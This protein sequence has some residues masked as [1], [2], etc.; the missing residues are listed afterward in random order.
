MASKQSEAIRDM[1]RAW[2]E[3]GRHPERPRESRDTDDRWGDVTAEPRGIDYVEVDAGG[4]PSM[5]LIP[6]GCAE[7]RVLLCFHG[8]GF[9][10]GSLYTHRKLFGHL[11]KAVSARALIAHYRLAPEHVHPAPVEDATA[12]HEWLLR[13]RVQPAHMALVGDS[14]GGCLCVTA[15][16]RARER[17]RP[18][19]AAAMLISPWVDMEVCGDSYDYN[20]DKEPFFYREVVRGLVG[21]FLGPGGNPRDPLANPLY[22]DLAGLPPL[23]IQAGADE[24]LVDDARRLDARARNAGVS[25]RLDIFPEQLHTF[26]MAAGRAPEADDAIRRLAAW[27]RPRLGLAE[28]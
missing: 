21:M 8:G 1:Y 25:T 2:T 17:G 19:P 10:G 22:A 14:A 9:V 24:T 6:K 28:R 23:Y 7:D 16:L 12:A 13:Q 5:W 11:A 27:V 18:L 3:A 20:N 26:Q 15:M 4:I